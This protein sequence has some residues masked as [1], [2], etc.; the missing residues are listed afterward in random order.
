MD[1]Q[2]IIRLGKPE[3]I[4]AIASVYTDS[5]RK[6][7]SKD[8]APDIIQFWQ[9]STPPE[10]RLSSIHNKT[11]WVAEINQQIVGYLVAVPGEIIALF[12]SPSYAGTGIGRQ[13]CL[14]GIALSKQN[15]IKHI[16]IESTLTAAGF[17]K[18]FG[19]KEVSRGYF[20]HGCDDIKIPV[21]H[22]VLTP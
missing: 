3:D 8:Y 2:I 18:K 20:S 13:L 6:L 10:Y 1:E 15:C 11:L 12:I 7:C 14:H 19:F 4:H 22:M 16:K 5:V 9:T 17:Y 21:I